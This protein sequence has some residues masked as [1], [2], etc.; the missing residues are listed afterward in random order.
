MTPFGDIGVDSMGY[1]VKGRV[2]Y[3]RERVER[4]PPDW[5][6]NLVAPLSSQMACLLSEY[7]RPCLRVMWVSYQ[8]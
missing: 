5:L 6:A 1:E 4:N 7:G 3:Q 8:S 2:H